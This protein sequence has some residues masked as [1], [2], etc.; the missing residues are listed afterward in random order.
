MP[1]EGETKYIQEKHD[2]L[3]LKALKKGDSLAAIC[4]L[5]D[6]SRDTLTEW[7]KE[8][9]QYYKPTLSAS[10]KIGLAHGQIW[11][12]KQMKDNLLT[13]KGSSFNS[14]GWIFTMKNR[15]KDDYRDKVEEEKPS[16]QI[17][18]IEFKDP[19]LPG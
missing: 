7:M 17:F 2:K 14:T 8:G 9:G 3:A 4:V 19:N 6:I 10:I 12:E 18:K 5:F 1:K 13:I 16:E 15:F 11:W